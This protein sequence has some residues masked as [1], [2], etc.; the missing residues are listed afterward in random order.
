VVYDPYTKDHNSFG[1][2]CIVPCAYS[3]SV[4]MMN[5]YLKLLSN[6]LEPGMAE[7]TSV[8][9]AVLKYAHLCSLNRNCM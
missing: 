6:P 5:C 8:A 9:V 7:P 4:V 1:I 2:K 3:F